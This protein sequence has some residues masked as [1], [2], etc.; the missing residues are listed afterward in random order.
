MVLT[1]LPVY[2]INFQEQQDPYN[3]SFH[4]MSIFHFDWFHLEVDMTLI[5]NQFVLLIILCKKY[6]RHAGDWNAPDPST[7]TFD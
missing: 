5:E 1:V 3:I 4:Y 7:N 6:V 2:K